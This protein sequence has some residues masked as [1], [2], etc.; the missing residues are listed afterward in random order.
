MF[1]VTAPRLLAAFGLLGL[2]LLFASRSDAAGDCHLVNW[3]ATT[4][5]LSP[6]R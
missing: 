1:R 5:M 2:A 4:C 6:L 3:A